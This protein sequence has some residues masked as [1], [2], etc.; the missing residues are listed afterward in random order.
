MSPQVEVVSCGDT[1]PRLLR[2]RHSVTSAFGELASAGPGLHYLLMETL[3]AEGTG[4]P[5]CAV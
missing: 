5:Y 3:L 1:R 4:F 2:I